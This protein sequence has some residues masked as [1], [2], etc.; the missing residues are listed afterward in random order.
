MDAN[1]EADKIKAIFDKIKAGG[2]FTDDER[3]YIVR[4]LVD[5]KAMAA[6]LVNS[7]LL[8]PSMNNELADALI[9]VYKYEKNHTP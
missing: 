5:N 1:K 4:W 8:P 6:G 3:E 7:G 2:G 9:E